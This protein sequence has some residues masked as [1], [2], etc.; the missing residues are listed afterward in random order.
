MHIYN[1]LCCKIALDLTTS[2]QTSFRLKYKPNVIAVSCFGLKLLIY[3]IL[4]EEDKRELIKRKEKENRC[5]QD[6]KIFPDMNKHTS[7]RSS[8]LPT[9]A[10]RTS[11]NKQQTSNP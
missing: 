2:S 5:S 11:Q 6:V 7:I 3:R 10:F 9:N 8:C 4:P 1:E